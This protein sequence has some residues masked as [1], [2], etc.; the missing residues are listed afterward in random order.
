MLNLEAN[1]YHEFANFDCC[2]QKPPTIASLADTEIEE[3]QKKL[4]VLLPAGLEIDI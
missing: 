4:L 1:A 3:C 2:Q